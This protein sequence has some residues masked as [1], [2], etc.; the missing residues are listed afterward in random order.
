MVTDAPN[1]SP[2]HLGNLNLPEEFSPPKE[3]L[4]AAWLKQ[5]DEFIEQDN[6]T[7]ISYIVCWF[8]GGLL[9]STC[10]RSSA[11]IHEVL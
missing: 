5:T 11:I 2:D 4:L 8:D 3:L 1:N 10:R 6:V 7:Q 9:Q